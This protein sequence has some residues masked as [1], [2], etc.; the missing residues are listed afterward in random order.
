MSEWL[1]DAIEAD[2]WDD[3]DVFDVPDVSEV[4][5]DYISANVY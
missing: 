5:D 2:R 4:Y 3:V 1:R